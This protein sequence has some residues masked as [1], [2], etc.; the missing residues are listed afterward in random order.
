MFAHWIARPLRWC[1]VLVALGS[2]LA[3]LVV[4]LQRVAYPYDI[5]FVEDG[6]LM[7][8]LRV[9][10]GQPIFIAPNAEFAPHVYMPLTTWLGGLAF[11]LTGPS[12]LPLRLLSLAATLATGGLIVAIARRESRSRLLAGLSGWLYLAG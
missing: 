6:M 7:Q 8:A 3:Y 5:D 2:A 4:A 9:A 11:R 10:A 1:L 12:F